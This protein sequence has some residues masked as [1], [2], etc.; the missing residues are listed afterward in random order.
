MER[1]MEFRFGHA[2]GIS[3]KSAQGYFAMLDKSQ[4]T[5]DPESCSFFIDGADQDVVSGH[6]M[7]GLNS[8]S[9]L[10]RALVAEGKEVEIDSDTAAARVAFANEL[11]AAC[12][13]LTRLSRRATFVRDLTEALLRRAGVERGMRV[14]DL[15]CGIGDTSLLLAKLVGPSGLVVGV[16][17]SAE[18]IRVAERRATVAGRCYWARFVANDLGTFVPDQPFDVVVARFILLRLRERVAASRLLSHQVRPHQVRPFGII[19]LQL[20]PVAQR[21]RFVESR[22]LI[23]VLSQRTP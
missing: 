12:F 14:L 1:R 22:H 20:A 21:V 6:T 18:A 3:P 8:Y 10:P 17:P 23:R 7:A 5:V 15:G 19:A 11:G 2:A 4:K 13:E 16:D 9:V